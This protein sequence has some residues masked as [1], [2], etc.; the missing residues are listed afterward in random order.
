MT[1][2]MDSAKRHLTV[3][4]GVSG[5]TGYLAWQIWSFA[6]IPYS[7]VTRA[8]WVGFFPFLMF[9]LSALT[10]AITQK[11]PDPKSLLK[12]DSL[13]SLFSLPFLLLFVSWQ[14]W[15]S[16]QGVMG[17]FTFAYLIVRISYL[18]GAISACPGTNTPIRLALYFLTAAYLTPILFLRGINEDLW[19]IVAVIIVGSV[20]SAY[21]LDESARELFPNQ[22]SS[23]ILTPG[24]LLILLTIISNPQAHALRIIPVMVLIS[25]F[26]FF[27]F[28]NLTRRHP[29]FDGVFALAMLIPAFIL[30][31]FAG[32]S[33]WV[34]LVIIS[35]AWRGDRERRSLVITGATVLF[36][37]GLASAFIYH[38]GHI[39]GDSVRWALPWTSLV[40][41][42]FL[43]IGS[44]IFLTFPIL[45][46]SFMGYLQVSG[47]GKRNHWSIWLGFPLIVLPVVTLSVVASGEMPAFYYYLPALTIL[48]IYYRLTREGLSSPVFSAVHQILLMITGCLGISYVI[49]NVIMDHFE[50][51]LE[52]LLRFVAQGSDMEFVRYFPSLSSVNSTVSGTDFMWIAGIVL[53]IAGLMIEKTFKLLKDKTIW[54][55]TAFFLILAILFG[56]TAGAARNARVWMTIPLQESILL[57]PGESYILPVDTDDSV[58]RIRFHSSLSQSIHVQHGVTVA[59][60]VVVYASGDKQVIPI[61]AGIDTAEWA[62]D[63]PDVRRVIQHGKPPAVHT[64]VKTLGNGVTFN[65]NTFQG[66]F[67]LNSTEKI[68]EIHFYNRGEKSLDTTSITISKVQLQTGNIQNSLGYSEKI[69]IPNNLILDKNQE[70]YEISLTAEY[71]FSRLMVLSNLSNAAAVPGGVS[72][73]KITLWDE[74][75]R[76]EIMVLRTGIDSAEW[77]YDRRDL[78]GKI[79]HDRPEKAFSFKTS[80]PE[81]GEFMA[82]M[83]RAVK[84]FPAMKPVRIRI[85]RISGKTTSAD[86]SIRFYSLI[87]S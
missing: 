7:G 48:L 12:R 86:L 65:A 57:G 36:L 15:P 1:E 64:W 25:G 22:K 68:A 34:W 84:S 61:R 50:P 29:L 9:A 71:Q 75:D 38:N 4:A 19:S 28:K 13:A 49:G 44:G 11:H 53:L 76:S 82:H 32:V 87:L 80:D 14:S 6:Q 79:R 26:L 66:I 51:G 17:M 35:T 33:L 69:L 31:M 24:M 46:M 21:F 23:Q 56:V 2:S 20:L 59:S 73:V 81:L 37:I 41:G 30:P 63:R 55:D 74:T 54:K 60:I 85:E 27:H 45:F 52:S 39:L 47:T 67:N 70:F 43:D 10:M 77:A 3:M 72:I 18:Q 62:Y 5:L 58:K 83:Y 16:W 78:L 8:V 40:P 42:I